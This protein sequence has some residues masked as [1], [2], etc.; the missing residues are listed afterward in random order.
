MCSV[1]SYTD[2]FCIHQNSSTDLPLP[3]GKIVISS[4]FFSSFFKALCFCFCLSCFVDC[5]SDFASVQDVGN[6]IYILLI[7]WDCSHPILP[8]VWWKIFLKLQQSSGWQGNKVLSWQVNLNRNQNT[9]SK[10]D[11]CGVWCIYFIPFYLFLCYIRHSP[12]YNRQ[13]IRN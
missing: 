13:V 12:F 6:V 8:I 5:L 2:S 11:M 9:D 10:P 1:V 4:I 3:A 7:D